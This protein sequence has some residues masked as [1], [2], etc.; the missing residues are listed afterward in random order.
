MN[1]PETTF[2]A[3]Q[4]AGLLAEGLTGPRRPIDALL[5]RLYQ[6]DGAAWLEA[7]LG[8]VMSKPEVAELRSGGCGLGRLIALK[9]RAKTLIADAATERA[10]LG[11]LAS[12]TL[13]VAAA[14]AQ[15]N[16]PISSRSMQ[17][18]MGVLTEFA[19]VAPP[20]WRAQLTSAAAAAMKLSDG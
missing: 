11:A 19:G 17:E 6:P 3:A 4:A 7:A 8:E 20:A 16:A 18:W 10:A 12:Y 13:C 15:H 9:E 5:D 1:T 2:T 14:L